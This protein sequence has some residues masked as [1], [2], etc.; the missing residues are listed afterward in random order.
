MNHL[1]IKIVHGKWASFLSFVYK[2]I[3]IIIFVGGSHSLLRIY[4]SHTLGKNFYE[5]SILFDNQ[6]THIHTHRTPRQTERKNSPDQQQKQTDQKTPYN[7]HESPQPQPTYSP[8]THSTEHP[9][10]HYPQPPS[11]PSPRD[12]STSQPHPPHREP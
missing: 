9:P 8:P 1:L 3:N 5:I 10:S 11:Q 4:L 2:C 12:P 7:S 6:H